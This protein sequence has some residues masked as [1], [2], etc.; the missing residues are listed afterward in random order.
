MN[1]DFWDLGWYAE[2]LLKILLKFLFGERAARLISKIMLKSLH[3]GPGIPFPTAY[4]YLP[5]AVYSWGSNSEPI[6]DR[7][8]QNPNGKIATSLDRF[9]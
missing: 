8:V 6:E 4:F 2:F 9:I 1:P 3:I 7:S 5:Q